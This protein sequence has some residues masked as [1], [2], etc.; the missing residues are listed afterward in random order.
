MRCGIRQ[1]RGL[2]FGIQERK[3]CLPSRLLQQRSIP[4]QPAALRNRM[5]H[6][7][8][9]SRRTQSLSARQ[10]RSHPACRRQLAQQQPR[11]QT[12]KST[13]ASHGQD[14]HAKTGAPSSEPSRRSNRRWW[15]GSSTTGCFDG[16]SH[17]CAHPAATA[18]AAAEA[19]AECHEYGWSATSP[20][21]CSSRRRGPG[22]DG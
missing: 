17:E 21:S 10:A 11:S 4:R 18:S 5:Q 1:C 9:G 6:R 15:S 14:Q 12:P 13:G 19:T 7:R 2:E 3:L 8:L 16:Q 20:P 22:R